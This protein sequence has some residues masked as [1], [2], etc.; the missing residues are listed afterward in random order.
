MPFTREEGAPFLA[1]NTP[2]LTTR[3]VPRA[4]IGKGWKAVCVGVCWTCGSCQ[5]PEYAHFPS[6]IFTATISSVYSSGGP[7]ALVLGRA[8]LERLR[9][10][11][12]TRGRVVPAPFVFVW[13]RDTV[14]SVCFMFVCMYV[15][16]GVAPKC[17]V[18]YTY[19]QL[20]L[21]HNKYTTSPR[22][23]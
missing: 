20:V 2:G 17:M 23:K 9:G 14:L 21:A 19:T 10:W 1:K 5:Q 7:L 4:A 8:S 15:T 16:Q 13:E 22:K 12:Q 11:A 3:A 18:I 6:A